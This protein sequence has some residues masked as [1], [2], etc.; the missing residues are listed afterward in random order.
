MII[1]LIILALSVAA[2]AAT[3][4]LAASRLADGPVTVI[5]GV[6]DFTYVENRGAAF[7]MLSEHR[8]VFLI[9]SAVAIA[10]ILVYLFVKRPESRLVRVSLALIAGGGIGN[11]IDRVARGYVT[12]FI[13]VRFVKFYVFNVA[14]S[15]VTV[16]C[17]LL[18][19]W[20]I[21]DTIAERKKKAQGGKAVEAQESAGARSAGTTAEV[22]ETAESSSEAPERAE[23]P[24]ETPEMGDELPEDND[25]E[26]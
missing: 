3:K 10:A 22:P 7:G 15:C 5:E 23:S 12:D 17:A 13:D 24:K 26:R 25:D 21:L 8:W 16:G 9:F 2:D 6:L 1:T 18:V 4:A 11:M 19:L 20:M 14:D